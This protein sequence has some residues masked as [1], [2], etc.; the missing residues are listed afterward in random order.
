MEES[1]KMKTSVFI[2]VYQWLRK[3][4]HRAGLVAGELVKEI[5]I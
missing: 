1:H 3:S 5:E 2:C 4:S